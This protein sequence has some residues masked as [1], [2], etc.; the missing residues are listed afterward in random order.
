MNFITHSFITEIEYGHSFGR[1]TYWRNK[2]SN[3]GEYSQSAI[4]VIITFIIV[5][6][7]YIIR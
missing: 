4:I 2:S 1:S 6:I 3:D 7:P 5:N